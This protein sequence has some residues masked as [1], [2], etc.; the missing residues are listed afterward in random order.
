MKEKTACEADSLLLG[1]KRC[2]EGGRRLSSN[3]TTTVSGDDEPSEQR[4]KQTTGTESKNNSAPTRQVLSAGEMDN[5]KLNESASS[6]VVDP[7]SSETMGAIQRHDAVATAVVD[8]PL[9]ET[10]GDPDDYLLLLLETLCPH[11][12]LQVKP[13]H[14]LNSFFPIISEE[15]MSRYTMTVVN[16]ARNGDASGLRDYHS[17]QSAA[18]SS[19]HEHNALDCFN[20]FGEGLLNMACRRGFVSVVDLL[21]SPPVNLSVRVRD[22]YGRTPLHDACWN[23]EPQLE[24]CAWILQR[25]PSLFLVADKRGYTPFQ[26]ARES[27]WPVW[28]KFLYDH[29][30]HLKALDDKEITETF[31][32]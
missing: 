4:S 18:V 21:L 10:A 32:R 7:N 23:P 26:Y 1:R 13:A 3:R 31:K 9:P 25:D 20:R 22:D 27:D 30:V 16:L 2:S 12:K 15:Q 17:A 28:C 19:S 24:I 11:V 8:L 6:T 5:A 14:E 29:S